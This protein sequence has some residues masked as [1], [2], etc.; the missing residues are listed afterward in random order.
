MK[1]DLYIIFVSVILAKEIQAKEAKEIIAQKIRN[2]ERES[3]SQNV[4]L[5]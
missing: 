5:P 2:R 1:L 4:K 3:Q